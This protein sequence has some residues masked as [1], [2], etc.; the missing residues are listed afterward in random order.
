MKPVCSAA[1]PRS[2]RQPA[3]AA[4]S[5]ALASILAALSDLDQG[6]EEA[7]GLILLASECIAAYS[8][9]IPGGSESRGEIYAAIGVHSLGKGAVNRLINPLRQLRDGIETLQR[10]ADAARGRATE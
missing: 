4:A 6:I 3:P 8:G 5:Q 7:S 1:P 2:P 10:Q 9:V